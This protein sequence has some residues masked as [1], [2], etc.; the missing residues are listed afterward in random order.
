MSLV[1]EFEVSGSAVELPTVAAEYPD[2]S[3][4]IERFRWDDGVVHWFLWV[5][6]DRLD[7]VTDSF[8]D[9]RNA[10]EVGLVVGGESRRLYRVTMQGEVDH[11]PTE[12]LLDGALV[13]GHVRPDCLHL[14]GHVPGR[15]VL[16]GIWQFLRSHEID[17]E[18]VRISPTAAGED[19]GR[20]TEPQFEALVTAYEMGYF[21]E[22]QRVTQDEIAA[23][24]DISRSAVSERLRRAQEHLVEEQLGI[25]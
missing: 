12:I 20:L 7:R 15:D 23:E 3:I 22:S 2:L 1:A 5:D 19:T 25:V 16:R 9:L 8:G 13:R 17:I 11:V 24:L 10:L 18:I 6:G 14:V 21:D 4:E